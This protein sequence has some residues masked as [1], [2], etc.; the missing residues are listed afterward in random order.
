MNRYLNWFA[1]LAAL[2]LPAESGRAG[3]SLKSRRPLGQNFT[4]ETAASTAPP[5]PRGRRHLLR[6]EH[7]KCGTVALWPGLSADANARRSDPRARKG[8]GAV[9][10][11]AGRWSA[12]TAVLER[13][14]RQRHRLFL[15]TIRNPGRALYSSQGAIARSQAEGYFAFLFLQRHRSGF[16]PPG[17]SGGGP[18]WPRL[19]EGKVPA[20]VPTQEATISEATPSSSSS[21]G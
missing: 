19:L 18:M 1:G 4:G 15:C 13:G 3:A 2:A 11:S 8:D 14:R 7:G 10:P 12:I 20:T 16:G 17:H 5:P 6:H 21:R 9:Y